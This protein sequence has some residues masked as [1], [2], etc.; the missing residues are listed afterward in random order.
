M[1]NK[2]KKALNIYQNPGIKNNPGKI[3]GPSLKGI[4]TPLHAEEAAAPP[5]SK[6]ASGMNDSS[7]G[8]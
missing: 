3:V 7:F 2:G 6:P 1:G 4:S 5:P 8:K